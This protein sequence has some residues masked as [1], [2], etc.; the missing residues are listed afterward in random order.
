MLRAVSDDSAPTRSVRLL[1][2]GEVNPGVCHGC[3]QQ[4]RWVLLLLL[5]V[6]VDLATAL[7]LFGHGRRDAPPSVLV[8]SNMVL[9][10]GLLRAILL[11]FCFALALKLGLGLWSCGAEAVHE[12]P[13][14]SE[15][16]ELDQQRA[17]VANREANSWKRNL[18][19]GICFLGTTVESTYTGIQ[20]LSTDGE[21]ALEAACFTIVV[22]CMNAATRLKPP[23]VATRGD[24]IRRMDR[25]RVASRA[26]LGRH[27]LDISCG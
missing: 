22:V 5:L 25:G 12:T 10:L 4:R 2:E 23:V 15:S 21:T 24:R 20:V 1:N 7:T 11:S 9:I 3:L 27:G 19:M 6:V 17:A 16:S 13:L 26:F 14:S 8:G 18:V